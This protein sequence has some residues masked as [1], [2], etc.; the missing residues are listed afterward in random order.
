L[1]RQRFVVSGALSENGE[2]LPRFGA[3]LVAVLMADGSELTALSLN[4]TAVH[5]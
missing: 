5:D 4:F 2:E 3:Q 1:L